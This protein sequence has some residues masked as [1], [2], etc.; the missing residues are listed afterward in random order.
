MRRAVPGSPKHSTRPSAVEPRPA[1]ARGSAIERRV[2]PPHRT[3]RPS[4]RHA[5]PGQQGAMIDAAEHGP[6]LDPHRAPARPSTRVRKSRRLGDLAFLGRRGRGRASGRRRWC[7]RRAASGCGRHSGRG[8]ARARRKDPPR[9]CRC[10]G[11][12]VSTSPPAAVSAALSLA[13]S[14]GRRAERAGDAPGAARRACL[15]PWAPPRRSARARSRSGRQ[16]RWR[17]SNWVG[18]IRRT[19]SPQK[20]TIALGL[21]LSTT[22]RKSPI[23]ERQLPPVV[24]M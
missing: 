10:R 8:S 19:P 17:T 5:E 14:G 1:P 20:L 9:P 7:G 18:L 24:R 23:G 4:D 15:I 22:I 2:R 13:M 21:P 3:R 12:G 11:S 16:L 6:P